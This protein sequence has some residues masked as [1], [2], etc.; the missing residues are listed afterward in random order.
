MCMRV[1]LEGNA[2]TGNWARG[3]LENQNKLQI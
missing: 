2:W 3:S 1:N